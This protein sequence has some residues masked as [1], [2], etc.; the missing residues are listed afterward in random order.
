MNIRTITYKGV[1]KPISYWAK[2]FKISNEV[3]RA[4]LAS[5]ESVERTLEMPLN[6]RKERSLPITKNQAISFNKVFTWD[7]IS[8]I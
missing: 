2:K 6:Y 4:R 3:I 5:G 1:T 7:E 8:V